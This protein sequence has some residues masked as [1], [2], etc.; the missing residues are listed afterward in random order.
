MNVTTNPQTVT[1]PGRAAQARKRAVRR[2]MKRIVYATLALGVIAAIAI[3][4]MPRP[5]PA[6]MATVSRGPLRV[7]VDEDGQARVKDRYVVSAPPV[8]DQ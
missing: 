8:L 4:W 3:A 1:G 7:T 2:V 6:E 5:V